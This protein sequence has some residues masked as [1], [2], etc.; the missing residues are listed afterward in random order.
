MASKVPTENDLS[1]ETV[2]RAK[3]GDA[4]AFEQL[5]EKFDGVLKRLCCARCGWPDGEDV[6]QKIWIEKLSKLHTFTGTTLDEFSKFLLRDLGGRSTDNFRVKSRQP[7]QMP[8][9][10]QGRTVEVIDRRDWSVEDIEAK[11][12]LD[13][14]VAIVKKCL[15]EHADDVWI[16]FLRMRYFEGCSVNQIA[17][18]SGMGDNS[19]GG[20]TKRLKRAFKRLGRCVQGVRS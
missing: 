3:A 6:A 2:L 17:E 9:D 18:L 10:E 13:A 12:L 4:R 5:V 8:T 19:D 14:Q 20:V 1:D 16:G 11:E 15:A 7:K